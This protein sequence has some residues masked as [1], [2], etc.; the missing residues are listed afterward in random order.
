MDDFKPTQ[1]VKIVEGG[2]E[3]LYPLYD[4]EK[5]Y[6]F[7]MSTDTIPE[8]ITKHIETN[9]ARTDKRL[10]PVTEVNEEPIALVAYGPTLRDW[11]KQVHDY[12][13]VMSMSGS[14]KFLLERDIVPTWHAEIDYRE[15]KAVHTN[16]SHPDVKYLMGSIV[17]SATF[18]NVKDRD[19]AVWNI[20]I[21]GITYPEGEIIIPS[22][23]DIGQSSILLARM[24]GF[25]NMALFG[26][27]YTFAVDSKETHAGFHNGPPKNHVFVKTD[28]KYFFTSDSLARGVLSFE[29]LIT[30]Y[31]DVN[32]T[33]FGDGLLNAYMRKHF[34]HG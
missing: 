4:F 27:D 21:D 24:L 20:A 33:M 31:P 2:V 22:Y 14:H 30:D 12:K 5:K 9:L 32:L 29:Q 15:R 6:N 10:V 18:D 1:A 28:G 8:E 19:V 3:R 11:W 25:R 26:F 34:T 17:H 16:P 23:W 7:R 13:Y